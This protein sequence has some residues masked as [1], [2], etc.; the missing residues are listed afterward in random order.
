MFFFLLFR[1]CFIPYSETLIRYAKLIKKIA[2]P[3]K[4]FFFIEQR[5]IWHLLLIL[6]KLQFFVIFFLFDLSYRNE[7]GGSRCL[8]FPLYWTT[9]RHGGTKGIDYI[10]ASSVFLSFQQL[11]SQFPFNFFFF[12]SYNIFYWTNVY[13]GILYHIWFLKLWYKYIKSF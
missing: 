12:L 1:F 9:P 11:P 2:P 4:W 5:G 13:R 7:E 8:C 10:T 3:L 6:F